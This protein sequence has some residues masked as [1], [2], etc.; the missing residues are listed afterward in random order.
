M[1][2]TATSKSHDPLRSLADA[3]RSKG[4]VEW[5]TAV[6]ADQR[7]E[8]IRGK[9]LA[10]HFRSHPEQMQFFV[11][12]ALR[13]DQQIRELG[14]LMIRRRLFI[15]AD[16]MFKKPKPGKKRL[17]K[18]PH[19]LV[20]L[21][22]DKSFAEE[23]FYAWQYE[24]PAS[25]W[26]F[27]LSA[28]LVVVVM[29]LCLFPLAPHWVKLAAVY[30]SMTLLCLI[31]AVLLVRGLLALVTW[32]AL[33]RCLWLFPF[34]LSEDKGIDQAFWPIFELEDEREGK[35][36][37]HWLT[38]VALAAALGASVWALHV[39]APDRT[40]LTGAVRGGHDAILEMLN[41]HDRSMERLGTGADG[42]AGNASAGAGGGGA[43]GFG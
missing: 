18:W 19:K 38:R 15:K 3:L 10:A 35:G 36:R 29:A 31:F 9:D 20:P 7:V 8:F 5:R 30:L 16:R 33:G 43:G 1:A 37:S 21:Y 41:L 2:P 24:R 17:V 6:M 34:L 14:E 11:S 40:R 4:G 28:L 42:K 12:K 22:D 27:A 25:P 39:Y 13:K 26:L 32:V 23:H